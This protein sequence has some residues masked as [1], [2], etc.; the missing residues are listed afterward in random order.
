MSTL[1]IKLPPQKPPPSSAQESMEF[2]EQPTKRARKVPKRYQQS[3]LSE[4]RVAVHE[5]TRKPSVSRASSS[6]P[7]RHSTAES[8]PSSIADTEIDVINEVD[9]ERPEA[10]SHH[11]EHSPRPHNTPAVPESARVNRSAPPPRK[12]PRKVLFSDSEGDEY[13]EAPQDI[14]PEPEEDDDDYFSPEERSSAKASKGKG[15]VVSGKASA[16]GRSA[17]RKAKLDPGEPHPSHMDKK[18]PMKSSAIPKK[19]LKSS[20][21]VDEPIIDVVGDA[22]GTPDLP[23]PSPAKQDSPIPI[24][25][26]KPKL[27]TIKKTKLPGTAGLT[28]PTSAPTKKPPSEVGSSNKEGGRKSLLVGNTDIDLSNKSIYQELFSKT[29]GVDGTTPRRAKEE[30]RRKELNRMRDEARFKRTAEAIHSFDLQA[31]FDKISHFEEILRADHSSALYPNFLAAKWRE[32]W[33]RGRRRP[34]EW[35]EPTDPMNGKEEGELG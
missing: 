1:R 31:Q 17:K 15:K 21:K 26:K 25:P 33:E 6:K 34:K 7:R 19:R 29:G 3:P 10:H 11:S 18:G 28:T 23:S 27:P 4:E 14:L 20:A 30:E 16:G 8:A 32:V 12:K 35:T 2:R 5:S 22:T 24:I 9:E 13:M